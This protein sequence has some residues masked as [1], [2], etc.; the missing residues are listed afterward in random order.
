MLYGRFFPVLT[1]LHEPESCCLLYQLKLAEKLPH[2]QSLC[3]H[4]MVIRAYKHLLRS[5]IASVP[6]HENLA[7]AIAA[8]LNAMLGTHDEASNVSNNVW[9][10]L[11]MFIE[12][13]FGWKLADDGRPELRKFAVLRGLCHKVC[14]HEAFQIGSHSTHASSKSAFMTHLKN[15]LLLP[16]WHRVGSS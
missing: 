11:Q 8:A 4:E 16:G 9:R 12:K 3:I 5:V 6:K 2:V 10:W 13:R 14:I 7:A 15:F 1:L